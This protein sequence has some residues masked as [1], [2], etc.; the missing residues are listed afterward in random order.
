[1]KKCYLCSSSFAAFVS[2][3]YRNTKRYALLVVE[4]VKNFQGIQESAKACALCVG[5]L[6]LFIPRFSHDSQL[7]K[8][9]FSVTLFL[10]AILFSGTGEDPKR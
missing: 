5:C 4:N 6:H 7:S 3:T 1:M 9:H 2:L 8:K 10:S